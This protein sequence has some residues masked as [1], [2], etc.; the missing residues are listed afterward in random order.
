[1]SRGI[2]LIG[3]DNELTELREQEYHS[4]DLLQALLADHPNLLPGD[5]IDPSKPRKWLLVSRELDLA[6]G[7]E[8]GGR[9]Y[10]DHL[11]LDQD[12]IPTL[13]EVKRSSD[14][15]IRREIVGQIFEYA[16]NAVLYWPIEKLQS[17]FERECA[18]RGLSADEAL[19]EFLGINGDAATFWEQVK[20]NLQAGKIRLVFASDEISTELRRIVEFL[21]KQMDPAEVLAVE[22]KQFV[23]GDNVRTL[24][25]SVFGQTEEAQQ[26]KSATMSPTRQ[27]DEETFFA[28]LLARTGP[29]AVGIA[30]RLLEW[31]KNHATRISW[32]KGRQWG[33]FVPVVR[34]NEIDYSL[35]ATYTYGAAQLYFAAYKNNRPPFD[36]EAKRVELL[37][38][39]NEID[40]IS[41]PA[42][43]ISLYPSIQLVDLVPND[44]LPQ[45][46]NV[47]EW[48]IAEI[49]RT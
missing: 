12:A 38:K 20:T 43:A 5:Q 48:M 13:V 40:G 2:F 31:A 8:T 39:F 3:S 46:V 14:T 44:R 45:L 34:H 21:N 6:D 11:L 9:W 29:A 23:G 19:S 41:L 26:R 1:M 47:F 30:R 32:G 27:W 7:P 42:T 28:D 33:S 16:A 36:A 37:S 25:P 4:E 22:I 15:R 17:R 35:F 49:R 18:A 24:V 10:V